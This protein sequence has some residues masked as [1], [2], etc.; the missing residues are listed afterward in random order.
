MKTITGILIAF[1]LL[2]PIAQGRELKIN[3]ACED[4]TTLL[5]MAKIWLND[6][7]IIYGAVRAD[8]VLLNVQGYPSILQTVDITVE[9]EPGVHNFLRDSAFNFRLPRP[10]E[11]G[12]SDSRHTGVKKSVFNIVIPGWGS[13]SIL[14]THRIQNTNWL[15][16][17]REIFIQG[18]TSG[19]IMSVTE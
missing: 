9:A 12:I 15:S 18:T 5:G 19:F 13:I 17:A 8:F 14:G 11:M 3:P 2:V 10:I 1:L 7:R 6:G 4:D 16:D